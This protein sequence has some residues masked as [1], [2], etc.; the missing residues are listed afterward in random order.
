VVVIGGGSGIGRATALRFAAEGAC[1]VV[2]DL[3]AASAEAVAAEIGERA[4]L[5]LACDVRDEASL[6]ALFRRT[7]LAFGGLDAVFY[8]AGKAPRFAAVEAITRQDLLE[9]LEIH[10][11]GALLAL[12]EAAR[13]LRRQGTGGSLVCSVSKAA[14]APGREAAAYGGSKAAL[15]HALRVAAL[16]LGAHG[17]RVNAINADQ[18]DTPL[19]RRFVAERAAQR[20]RSFEEQLAQYRERNALGVSLIP[21]EAVAEI[22]AWLASDRLPY[23][24]G[25]ILTVDG[26]LPDAMPR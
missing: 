22:A 6:V 9:Q 19:F 21:A 15:Q 17:I 16:E 12:R 4:A 24:T 13:V 26:G 11:V 2:S 1:V 8:T 5:G 18:V 14:L 23:T 7:V 25:D 20:G 3:D 10:Y